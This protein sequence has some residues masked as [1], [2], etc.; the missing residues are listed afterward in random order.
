MAHQ[1]Q[2]YAN[3]NRAV[4]LG[5]T[6]DIDYDTPPNKGP[7]PV[8]RVM[9]ALAVMVGQPDRRVD[10]VSADGVGDTVDNQPFLSTDL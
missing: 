3:L 1:L 2:W 7:A 5:T 4:P 8:A 9:A 10:V 6:Q